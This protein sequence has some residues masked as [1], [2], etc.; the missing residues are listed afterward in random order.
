VG[1]AL[2]FLVSFGLDGAIRALRLPPLKIKAAGTSSR[3]GGDGPV[4]GEVEAPAF[5]LFRSL[6]GRRTGRQIQAFRW[7]VDPSS[8]LPAFAFGFFSTSKKDIAE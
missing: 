2:E 1:A 6:T 8:Y 4:F 7:T 3:V 5:E